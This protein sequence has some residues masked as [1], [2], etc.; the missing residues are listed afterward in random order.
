MAVTLDKMTSEFGDFRRATF[1]DYNAVIGIDPNLSDGLDY[2][3]V[4]YHSF[5]HSHLNVLTV[6]E[7]PDRGVSNNHLRLPCRYAV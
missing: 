1:E 7:H 4:L 6:M 2:V 5:L 3:P